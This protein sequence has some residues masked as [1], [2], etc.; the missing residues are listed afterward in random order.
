MHCICQYIIDSKKWLTFLQ[1]DFKNDNQA[2]F[3]EW[4][5]WYISISSLTDFVFLKPILNFKG[6]KNVICLKKKMFC[7]SKNC[8]LCSVEGSCSDYFWKKSLMFDIFGGFFIVGSKG[9]L[10]ILKQVGWIFSNL[11]SVQH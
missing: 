7:N 3:S 2:I 6:T 10:S 8:T 5:G 1:K 9:I 4:S 11:G